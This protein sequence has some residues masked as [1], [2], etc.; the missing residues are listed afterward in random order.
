MKSFS[1]TFRI[2]RACW[3]CAINKRVKYCDYEY[4]FEHYDLDFV[5]T[6]LELEIFQLVDFL[7]HDV[8]RLGLLV[9]ETR[10][11]VNSLAKKQKNAELPYPMTSEN[12]WDGSFDGHPTMLR[13]LE[14]FDECGSAD[15]CF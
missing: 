1:R 8:E 4:L 11:Q 2:L 15:H 10:D 7:V 6:I 9:M 5:L 3:K 14:L 12:V 13:Y